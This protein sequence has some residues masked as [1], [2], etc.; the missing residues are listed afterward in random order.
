MYVPLSLQPTHFD[1]FINSSI[2]IPSSNLCFSFPLSPWT[3][4][5]V[6]IFSTYLRGFYLA[7]CYLFIYVY[8]FSLHACLFTTC[9]PDACRNR[10][11]MLDAL[12]LGL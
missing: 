9:M 5:Y 4:T 10:K 8:M 12:Q 1:I 3:H 2:Q 7:F 11:R 6:C